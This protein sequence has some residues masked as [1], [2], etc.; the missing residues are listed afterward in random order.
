MSFADKEEMKQVFQYPLFE[1]LARRRTRRFPA[2]AIADVGM[3]PH[4]STQP[5]VPLNDLETALLCWAGAGITGA[6]CGDVPSEVTTQG[7]ASGSWIGR[8]VPSACNVLSTK[9]F[10]TDDNGTFLYQPRKATRAV[11]ID[12]SAD[13]DKIMAYFRNDS[14]KL[15]DKRAE[16]LPQGGAACMHWNAG[17][18]GTTVF[19]PVVDQTEEYL[20]TLLVLFEGRGRKVIDDLRGG[21]VAGLQKWVDN[22]FIKGAEV[23]L[24]SFEFNALMLNFAPVSAILQNISLAAEAMGLGTVVF[25]GYSG[26]MMLGATKVTK[27]LGFRTTVTRDGKVNPV[28]LDGVLQPYCPPYYKNMDE[29]VDAFVEM[30]FGHGG[31]FDSRYPG[32]V[33]FKEGKKVLDR[34]D[35]PGKEMIAM[36]KDYCNYIYDTYGR[37]P[38]ITDTILLREWI[39]VHHLDLDFYDKYMVP[40]MLNETHRS[41]MATWHE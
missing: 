3:R 38:A 8:T 10:F 28:G 16:F 23:T 29:A 12:T 18:P 5:P 31:V 1:A 25:A 26:L 22:G 39:Q 6:I 27:G 13:R 35:K 24:S 14:I 32:V 7:T 2:G 19:M 30:K 11:E 33:P 40:E 41:H 37:F 17:K 15:S 20:N 4:T 36:V 9:L 34:Y 21:Q